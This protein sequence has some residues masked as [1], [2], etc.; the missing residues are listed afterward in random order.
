MSILNKLLSGVN[1]LKTGET[2][3]VKFSGLTVSVEVIMYS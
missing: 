2:V 3:N 1:N